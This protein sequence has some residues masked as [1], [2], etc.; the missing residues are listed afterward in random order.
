MGVHV[1]E[2]QFLPASRSAAEVW[3]PWVVAIAR[4]GYAARGLVYLLVGGLAL[5]SASGRHG[6]KS[7]Q[8]DAFESLLAAPA[9]AVLL[10]V[11]AGGLICFA[12]WRSIQAVL[13]T[14]GHGKDGKG[15]IIRGG[16]L[17]GA[18]T[19]VAM[20]I[21]ALRIESGEA[22]HEDG[23]RHWSAWLLSEP[24]G[25]WM[26]A[27]VAAGIFGAGVAHAARAIRRTYEKWLGVNPDTMKKL[28]W[29]FQFGLLARGL[30]FCM[31]GSFLA[32]AAWTYDHTRAGGLAAVFDKVRSQPFGLMMLALLAGGLFAFGLYGLAQA[33]WR[34]MDG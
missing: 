9:G 26:L 29:L 6:G 27:I 24:L 12:I 31:I 18:V 11:L 17:C 4:A 3:R 30:V 10:A 2:H 5:L 21:A 13:D 32:Y 20:A 19:Q 33:W 16:F 8:K 22:S 15:L 25:R 14:D 7:D 1:S 28:R 23:T 34:R